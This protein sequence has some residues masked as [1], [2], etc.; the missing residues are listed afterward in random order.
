MAWC[1]G[2]D[3]NA[4][5][6]V[7]ERLGTHR[8][9]NH[10]KRLNDFIRE[11]T[12]V[13]LPLNGAQFTWTGNQGSQLNTQLDGFLFTKDW[14][15]EDPMPIQEALPNSGLDHIPILLHPICQSSAL[16]PFR[17]DLMW[18]EVPEFVDKVNE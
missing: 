10:M 7:G 9:F 13:D 17:F 15:F 16:Q 14:M 1:V 18:P 4:V 2:G 3:F 5:R 6:Y 11:L 8:L 12:L